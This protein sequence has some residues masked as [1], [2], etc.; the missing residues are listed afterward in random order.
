[1][2]LTGRLRTIAAG[3]AGAGCVLL[4]AGCGNGSSGLASVG[5]TATA[6]SQA[7]AQSTA[8][9]T[10]QAGST[11][12]STPSSTAAAATSKPLKLARFPATAD[13][14]L[15]RTI[16]QTWSGLR[17][18]YYQ[19]VKA[20]TAGQLSQWFTG[21]DWTTVRADSLQL[22][23]DPE[24]Q[25]LDAAVARATAGT[26]ASTKTGQAVDRACSTGS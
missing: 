16:C 5:S 3:A 25:R 17:S 4:A 21:S 15:A 13:G 2:T 10:G 23:V 20:D 22:A 1:M 18:Q 14:E 24:Y 12:Q 9:S 26:V 11:S 19:R 7:T 6:T 8:Q